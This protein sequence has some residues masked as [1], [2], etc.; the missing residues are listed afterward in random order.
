MKSKKEI[1]IDTL[2]GSLCSMRELPSLIDT[3]NIYD[4]TGHVDTDFLTAILEWMA[5][6]SELC[7]GVQKAL[8]HILGC[9]DVDALKN[10]GRKNDVGAKWPAEEIL[11]HCTLEDNVLKL[12]DVPFNKKSYL[13]AKRWIEEAGGSW[14]GGKVQGFTFPFNAQRVFGI[15]SQG[16]RC[17]L[18]QDFQFF[19]TPAAVADRLVACFS[20]IE[21]GMNILEPSAGTGS[22]VNAVLRVCPDALVDCFELMPENRELLEKVSGVR[23][24]GTDF[25]DE[26]F[27]QSH[28]S[29]YDR[30]IA[31]PPFSNNQ[32]IR[33][34]RMMYSLLKKGG[35]MAVIV[36]N[37]WQLGSEKESLS[38][39][40]FLME[41]NA[42]L[43]AVEGGT[44]NESGTSVGTNIIYI[45]K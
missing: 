37:H 34:V 6:A 12:P 44:F 4:E 30:I 13:E 16:K 21:P 29:S 7:C 31:N 32:D 27:L 3:E 38:F 17:N 9:D 39:Q 5:Q 23:L 8:N 20:S 33:H 10:K 26:N 1:L 36:S 14:Q 35:E 24:I 43:T 11:R 25:T 19:A 28:R 22:L 18:K 40:D 45:H 42:V 2:H 41:T 15:L